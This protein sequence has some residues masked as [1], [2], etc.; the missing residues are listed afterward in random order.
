[1]AEKA[2]FLE[3]KMLPCGNFFLF[4]GIN[5]VQKNKKDSILTF[6]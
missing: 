6:I 1:V 3:N 2:L 4:V 5:F